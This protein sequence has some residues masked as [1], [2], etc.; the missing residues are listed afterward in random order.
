M[1]TLSSTSPGLAPDNTASASTDFTAGIR[2]HLALQLALGSMTLAR[3]E[4]FADR[5]TVSLRQ[6]L[7]PRLDRLRLI[8]TRCTEWLSHPQALESRTLSR[9]ATLLQ[10]ETHALEALSDQF[11]PQAFTAHLQRREALSDRFREAQAVPPGEERTCQT[12]RACFDALLRLDATDDA[13][14]LPKAID[15]MKAAVD[16]LCAL[17]VRRRG[18]QQR[19]AAARA[20]LPPTR[21]C[22]EVTRLLLERKRLS[23]D[24]ATATPASTAMP[25]P[26]TAPKRRRMDGLRLETVPGAAPPRTHGAPSTPEVIDLL[27]DWL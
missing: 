4:Q 3:L 9:M 13:S 2:D 5:T 7:R 11:S 23:R 25:P 1:F 10:D 21:Q 26:Q 8:E 18:A 17:V 16:A 12:A 14:Q 6:K 19:Q 22:P 27:A 15:D 24:I 20:T